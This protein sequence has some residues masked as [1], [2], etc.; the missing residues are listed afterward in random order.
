MVEIAS[1]VARVALQRPPL[2]VIDI[3]MM[4]EL[5]QSL[6]R[7]TEIGMAITPKWFKPVAEILAAINRLRKGAA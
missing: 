3:P 1:P 6:A 7:E 4:T 5:A 2:N